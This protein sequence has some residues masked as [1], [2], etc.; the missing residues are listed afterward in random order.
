[1]VRDDHEFAACD[2]SSVDCSGLEMAEEKREDE[3]LDS[4]VLV[5]DDEALQALATLVNH[6]SQGAEIIPDA[7]ETLR[8]YRDVVILDLLRKKRQTDTRSCSR[9]AK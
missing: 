9:T 6:C 8:K 1:M 2:Q 5:T 3:D 4:G 7:G